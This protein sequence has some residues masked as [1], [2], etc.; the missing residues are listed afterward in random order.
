MNEILM[1]AVVEAAAFLE[2][3]ADDVLDPDVAVRELESM[4]YRLVQLNERAKRQ[5]VAFTQA[6]ADCASSVK[7][8]EF[9]RQF[10]EAMGPLRPEASLGPASVSVP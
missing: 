8:R 5:L 10:P 1:R 7:Y 3:A 6:E 4:A 2:L 9:L